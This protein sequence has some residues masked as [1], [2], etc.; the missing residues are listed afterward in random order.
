MKV[1]C[2]EC[3]Y[4]G[5]LTACRSNCT[6]GSGGLKLFVPKAGETCDTEEV[7]EVVA[8]GDV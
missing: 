8:D 3:V 7:V 2:E 4:N 5:S 1:A 6:G